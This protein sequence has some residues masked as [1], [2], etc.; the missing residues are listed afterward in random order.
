MEYKA[1]IKYLRISPRKLREVVNMVK[2]RPL[3][4]MLIDLKF[5]EKKAARL[6]LKALESAVANAVNNFTVPQ[7]RLELKEMVVNE[8]PS[9]KRWRAASRGRAHPY[10]RPT[11]HIRIVLVQREQTQEKPQ[12]KS[13]KEISG[14]QQ[15]SKSPPQTAK[16][17]QV[18]R[19]NAQAKEVNKSKVRG[20]KKS[21]HTRV[22]TKK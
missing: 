7:E 22:R 4:K 17:K 2:K 19:A 8:G 9:F 21:N 20:R 13:T 1:E 11:S 18:Q 14:K 6:L 10:R 5:V 12:Q 16:A 15:K 3:A